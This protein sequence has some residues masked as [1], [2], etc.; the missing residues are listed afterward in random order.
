MPLSVPLP[1]QAI[2]ASKLP[3]WYLIKL[4]IIR[5][6]GTLRVINGIMKSIFAM[7]KQAPRMLPLAR[8]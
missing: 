8:Y 6:T 7:M 4:R 1:Q 3:K 5:P 2:S